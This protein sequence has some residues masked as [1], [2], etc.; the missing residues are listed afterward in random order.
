MAPRIY[1]SYMATTNVRSLKEI[2][3]IVKRAKNNE[4]K[5]VTTNGCFDILHIGH[6][7]NLEEAKKL[8]DLLIVGI[9]SD[10]S[11]RAFKGS[12]RP[13]IPQDERAELVAALSP[14]DYVFIFDEDTPKEWLAKIKPDIHVKGSDRNMDQIIEKD[15]VE[16]NGG[17]IALIPCVKDKS[18]TNVIEKIIRL[19]LSE[20]S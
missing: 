2:E 12:K 17:R 7:K 8:G 9:N 14:V 4:K 20:K 13:I 18:T 19:F 6:L 11:V 16:K 5:I 1:Y 10:R 3:E 15:T